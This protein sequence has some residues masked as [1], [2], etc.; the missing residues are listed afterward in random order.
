MTQV[1]LNNSRFLLEMVL[2]GG[3]YLCCGAA[4]SEGFGPCHMSSDWRN[5]THPQLDK[6]GNW[7]H[8]AF[9]FS[10]LV[11]RAVSRSWPWDDKN[12]EKAKAK[13]T[14]KTHWRIIWIQ[15]EK[16]SWMVLRPNLNNKPEVWWTE[17]GPHNGPLVLAVCRCYSTFGTTFASL[18]SAK[19]DMGHH[20]NLQTCTPG[21]PVW[22]WTWHEQ[23]DG[24]TSA[25]SEAL[26]ESL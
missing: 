22:C 21:A 20:E 26:L 16:S 7:E 11:L 1:G 9:L 14:W 4:G 3:K 23:K 17:V 19:Q 25:E 6:H 8:E 12:R 24:G 2:G 5:M 13:V 10:A 18:T 15:K